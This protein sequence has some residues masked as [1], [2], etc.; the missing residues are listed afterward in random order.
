MHL[1]QGQLVVEHGK[2]TAQPLL[3]LADSDCA[4]IVRVALPPIKSFGLLVLVRGL[5]QR[6]LR[7]VEGGGH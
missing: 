2:V 3:Q 5:E 7:C 6:V 1:L 4:P